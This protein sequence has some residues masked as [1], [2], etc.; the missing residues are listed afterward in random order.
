MPTAKRHNLP[1]GSAPPPTASPPKTVRAI[2][3][4]QAL[5]LVG[6]SAYLLYYAKRLAPSVFYALHG[7]GRSKNIQRK[8]AKS[9]ST[10]TPA[11]YPPQRRLK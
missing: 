9:V 6:A 8:A 2:Y 3:R 1:P 11:A 5:T 10:S 7:I 4:N